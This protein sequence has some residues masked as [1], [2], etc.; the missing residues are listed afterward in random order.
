MFWDEMI[1]QYAMI[2]KSAIVVVLYVYRYTQQY[3]L[4]QSILQKPARHEGR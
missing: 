1:H 4:E 2:G 3:A